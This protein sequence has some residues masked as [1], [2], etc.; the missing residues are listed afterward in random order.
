MSAAALP[1]PAAAPRPDAPNAPAP[2]LPALRE[3]LLLHEAPRQHDGAPGWTLEDPG[4]NL[5]FQ[6]GWPEAEMLARWALGDAER[7]VQTIGRD[8]TLALSAQDVTE[9]ARFLEV[10]DL[11]QGHGPQVLQRYQRVAQARRSSHW[12]KWALHH[13]PTCSSASRWRGPMPSCA[14]RCRGCGASSSIAVSPG[15]RRWPVH[16]GC[17]SPRGSGMP[18]CTSSRWRAQRWPAS[19]WRPPRCCTR[20]GMPTWHAIMAAVWPPWAWPSW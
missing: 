19:P 8:T 17:F 12:L 20:W 16:P 15:P 7:I 2:A 1:L 10:N 13:Y 5:F 6:I 11:T 3:E 18:S 4:R 14:R 9:F